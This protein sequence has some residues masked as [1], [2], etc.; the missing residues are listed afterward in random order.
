MTKFE[1]LDAVGPNWSGASEDTRQRLLD[2]LGS[3]RWLATGGGRRYGFREFRPTQPN[4]WGGYF[5]IE[6]R[7]DYGVYEGD[8]FVRSELAEFERVL[9]IFFPVDGRWVVHERR[10]FRTDLNKALVRD[11]MLEALTTATLTAVLGPVISLDPFAAELTSDQMREALITDQRR[12]LEVHI[13]G[14]AGARVPRDYRFFNPRYDLDEEVH[15]FFDAD[16]PVLDEAELEAA[17]SRDIRDS[18]IAQGLARAGSVETFAVAEP[19]A[20]RKVVT[21]R[22]PPTFDIEI[23]LDDPTLDVDLAIRIIA[24]RYLEG[25]PASELGPDTRPDTLWHYAERRGEQPEDGDDPD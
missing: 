25:Y 10:F 14:L 21:R 15:D 6:S 24:Q 17:P 9:C 12:V 13:R 16:L 7:M 5:A 20:G 8:T 23:A 11:L 3:D 1:V 19:G 4:I 18:R 22:I 2:S